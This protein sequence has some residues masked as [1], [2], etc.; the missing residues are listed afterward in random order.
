V[1]DDHAECRKHAHSDGD[2]QQH[3]EAPGAA[4]PV[5]QEPA[6]LRRGEAGGGGRV[7]VV[8]GDDD[9]LCGLGLLLLLLLVIVVRMR[10]GGLRHGLVPPVCVRWWVREGEWGHTQ[11]PGGL[12]R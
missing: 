7:R 10:G 6:A 12:F 11:K 2:G 8:R 1:V 5:P 4:R 9:W 3:R